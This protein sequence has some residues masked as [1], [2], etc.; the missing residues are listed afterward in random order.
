MIGLRYFAPW[1][2]VWL[3]ISDIVLIHRLL[4]LDPM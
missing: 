3:L 1:K 4:Y 2:S